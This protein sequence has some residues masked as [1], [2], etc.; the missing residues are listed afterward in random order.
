LYSAGVATLIR[1]PYI[2]VLAITDDFLFAT[3]DVAIWSAVEPGVGIIAAAAL[4]LRPLFKKFYG[5]SINGA[6]RAHYPFAG[7]KGELSDDTEKLSGDSGNFKGF[8]DDAVEVGRNGSTSV[9]QGSLIDSKLSRGPSL[10]S[11]LSRTSTASA[12]NEEKSAGW[13]VQVERTVEVSSHNR[14]ESRGS[15]ATVGSKHME[16]WSDE[17]M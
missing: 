2:Q 5:L 6:N 3:V 15:V 1:I 7:R 11:K 17:K 14:Q 8:D 10:L 12:N 13:Q 16:A 9:A 4:A